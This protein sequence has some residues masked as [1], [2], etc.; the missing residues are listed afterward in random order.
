[1]DKRVETA[2]RA[3]ARYRLGLDSFISSLNPDVVA[4][5]R[6][7]A[8]DKLWPSL[9]GEAQAMVEAIDTLERATDGRGNGQESAR[10]APGEAASQAP[11]QSAGAKTADSQVGQAP[12]DGRSPP[13]RMDDVRAAII[14]AQREPSIDA[15]VAEKAGESRV[16]QFRTTGAAPQDGGDRLTRVDN[17]ARAKTI[18]EREPSSHSP[19]G[20][21]PAQSQ[22]QQVPT[23]NAASQNGGVRL[24]RVDHDAAAK[25]EPS[26]GPSGGVKPEARIEEIATVTPTPQDGRDRPA[27]VD[28]PT[29]KVTP[30]R[31]P[32]FDPATEALRSALA[33][34][35]ATGTPPR[36][37]A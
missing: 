20:V 22:V 2:A 26:A 29:V 13:T 9:V 11:G 12:Q 4:K 27:S 37:K 18:P 16:E 23:A 1:M 3:M 24:T 7:G 34:L 5:V 8:E 17:G 21:A 32:S 30:Q 25:V 35:A 31:D 14:P 15:G 36:G 28:G 6:Q 10:A 19:G 33:A